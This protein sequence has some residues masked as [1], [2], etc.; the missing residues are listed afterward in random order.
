[1]GHDW[2][3]LKKANWNFSLLSSVRLK[4]DW[5]RGGEGKFGG[6]KGEGRSRRV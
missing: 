2:K 6:E 3:Y 4:M 5:K 1:M